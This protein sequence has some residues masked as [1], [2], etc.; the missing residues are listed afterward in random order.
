MLLL[1][2]THPGLRPEGKT[3]V[4]NDINGANEIPDGTYG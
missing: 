1:N 3:L 2:L 4:T